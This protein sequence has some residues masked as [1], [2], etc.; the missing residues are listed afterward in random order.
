MKIAGGK[1]Q[2]PV[3]AL[4]VLSSFF[5]FSE[6][7]YPR[8]TSDMAVNILMTPS[9]SLP[10]DIYFWGQ[11]R[12]GNLIP[13]ISHAVYTLSEWQPVVIVSIVHYL[14]L[15]AGFL[16]LMRFVK[17]AYSR[18]ILALVWFFPPWHFLEF[19]LI[20][21]GIQ[22]SLVLISL[23][24]LDRSFTT[25]V[26][27]KCLA[28]L[29]GFCF[30]FIVAVW[31]SD[32]ALGSMLALILTAL[33]YFWAAAKDTNK[34]ISLNGMMVPAILLFTWA[35]AGYLV[36]HYAKVISTPV[37]NYTEG[38][39]ATPSSVVATIKTVEESIVKTMLFSADSQI[40]SVYAWGLA[41]SFILLFF[42]IK[43]HGLRGWKI[44][45]NPWFYFFLF[46]AILTLAAV[47]LSR[48]VAANGAGRRYFTTFFMSSWICL[49]LWLENQP[50]NKWKKSMQ[51]ALSVVVI[52][53]SLSG[54]FRFYY[55]EI[56]PSRIR[57]IS[58]FKS[59]GDI[60]IIAEYWNAYMAAS[61]DPVHI[62]ATPHDKDYVRNPDLV[63]EV[64]AQPKIYLVKDGWLESFPD[65]IVQ[66]G[67]LL[68]KKGGPIHIADDC[69]NR[70]VLER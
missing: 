46:E 4:I 64:F 65:T 22:T 51:I 17:S 8:L 45:E 39:L 57:V 55:P 2:I 66:F 12:S 54:C 11:D 13:M 30:M 16:A 42:S 26:R 34:K 40:E 62:K 31:V 53:G 14:L 27:W 19:L 58:A 21:Y 36:L 41:A 56:K 69:I 48:W 37:Q 28:W 10:H 61:P 59:M 35:V 43:K 5:T 18:I 49:I 70:Y 32:M 63:P 3:I 67:R 47:V 52:A 24:F 20:L 50:K 33:L 23:N 68:R 38:F 9:F 60:G 29:S 44:T 6:N 25:R 7:Y 15:A 1:W